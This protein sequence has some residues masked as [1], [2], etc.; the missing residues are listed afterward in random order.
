[1][2]DYYRR[3]DSYICVWLWHIVYSIELSRLYVVL[4]CLLCCGRCSPV[5]Y[6]NK[7][8]HTIW[9]LPIAA[10]STNLHWP[11]VKQI[12]RHVKNTLSHG[13]IIHPAKT[14]GLRACSDGDWAGCPDDRRSTTC[15]CIYFGSNIVSLCAKKQMIVSRSSTEARLRALASTV[16][17]LSWLLELFF[18][19]HVCVLQI[20]VL[21]CEN[22]S[23]LTLQQTRPFMLGL[24]TL[25][26][27]TILFATE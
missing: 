27:I 24:S 20:P 21:W 4:F 25:S 13:I 15:F 23:P 3:V 18:E 10:L 19:L 2:R 22:V 16:A 7:T 26:S 11:A 14:F 17:E 9:R 5:P 6:L 12:L 8:W 1:M